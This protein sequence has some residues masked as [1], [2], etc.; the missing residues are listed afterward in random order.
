MQPP[1]L[2]EVIDGLRRELAAGAPAATIVALDPD[3]GRGRYAGEMVELDGVEYVH[4]PWRVWVDLA[5]RLG[6]RLRTPRPLAPPL[7]ALTFEPLAPA[8]RPPPGDPTEKYGVASEFA[9]V[10]KGEDPGFVL[11]LAD[12]LARARLPTPA[13]VLDLGVNTGDE[14]ALLM[15]LSPALRDHGRFVGVDHSASALAAARARFDPAQVELH[16]ADLG[17]LDA[18]ALG[19]FDLVL[20]IDTLH[21]P[22]LD[23]RAILRSIVQ[24]HLAPA[25]AVILGFP[26]CRYRDGEVVHG[27]RV[28]NYAQP[29]LGLLVK[30]VAFARSY[31]AQHKRLVF[32]TGKHD[33]LVTAVA[34]PSRARDGADD[35]GACDDAPPAPADR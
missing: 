19:R 5:E 7:L 22:G 30:D 34:L 35:G 6:L 32:V 25:G 20:S 10:R 4:R 1:S 31:L 26:N 18:L 23:G 12:A 27:A 24:R 28:R 9:R 8:T 15:A 14:L 3:A 17:D 29:E 16:R 13:R 11:D 33:V 21:S 2:V